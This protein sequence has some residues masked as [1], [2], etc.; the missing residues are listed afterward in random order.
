MR[1]LITLKNFAL[2]GVIFSGIGIICGAALIV[3]KGTDLHYLYVLL[4]IVNIYNFFYLIF[5]LPIYS[6]VT[7]HN[8]KENE[9]SQ[10]S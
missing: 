6:T 1:N 10:N 5:T 8:V 9:N 2:I 4:W 3:I 7:V